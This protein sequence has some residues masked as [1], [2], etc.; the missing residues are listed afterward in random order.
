M[1]INRTDARCLD[2]LDRAGR[3]TAGRLAEENSLTTGAVTAIIDR[4]ER[5]GLAR[6]VRDESDR[7]KVL[8]EPTEKAGRLAAEIYGEM[9]ES[10]RRMLA[11][12]SDERLQAFIDLMQSALDITLEN[13][14]RLRERLETET[15]AAPTEGRRR[16]GR[17][18]AKP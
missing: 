3:M 4:L 9:A 7:R 13:T 2:I 18:P 12:Y 5:A 16:D 6:R 14:A 1:G 11:P 17:R 15:A 8:V 10:G